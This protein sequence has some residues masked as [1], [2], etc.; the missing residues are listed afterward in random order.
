MFSERDIE[1]F[2][3]KGISIETIE[4]QLA[5]F[6]KGFQPVHLEAPATVGNGIMR[7][8]ENKTR[9]YIRSFEESIQDLDVIKFVPASGAASRMLKDLY[10]FVEEAGLKS[11]KDQVMK[12]EFLREFFTHISEFAFYNDL[13]KAAREKNTSVQDLLESGRYSDLLKLFLGEDRLGYGNLPKGLIKFHKYSDHQ[14]TSFEEHLVESAVLLK[15]DKSVV[16]LHFT[17][18]PEHL[19]KFQKHLKEVK[20]YYEK[21]FSVNLKVNFSTQKSSTDILAVDINNNPFRN[22]NGEIVFRPGGHGALLENLNDIDDDIIFIKNID[23]IAPDRIKMQTHRYKKLLAAIL[24]EYQKNIFRYIEILERSIPDER[25]LEEICSFVGKSICRLNPAEMKTISPGELCRLL[26][27][28]LNRPIRVCGVVKNV[29]EPG[30]RPFWIRNND[31]DL[32]LQ[33]IE[34]AQVNLSNPEQKEIFNDA[35]HFNPVD[36]VCGIRDVNGKKFNLL[37]FRDPEMALITEKSIEGYTVKAQELPG[38]W[39]GS[40]AHWN[41]IFVEVPIETFT[42]VKTINDLIKP[43]HMDTGS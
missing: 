29:G 2:R 36:I 32:S 11:E 25:I 19:E 1:H 38:L 23:N 6:R 24:M 40:M 39:N 26:L 37:K 28:K 3:S 35:T 16:K 41:T 34:S 22:K 7:L 12:T 14:R 20:D 27:I 4:Q 42:P 15:S 10:E 18:S 21:L 13:E 8:A 43:E 33:I 31:G 30:G 17:V 5:N 9:Q